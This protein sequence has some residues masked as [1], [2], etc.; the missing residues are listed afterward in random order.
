[1]KKIYLQIEYVKNK[2]LKGYILDL[3]R[4][5]MGIAAARKLKKGLNIIITPNIKLL[6][7]LQAEIIY[8]TKLPRKN[9]N[10]RTGVKFIQL[11][12][13]QQS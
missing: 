12:K 5:G 13:K 7:K 9:Y 2:K 4:S 10:C 6:P 11:D 1:M 3:S 8:T